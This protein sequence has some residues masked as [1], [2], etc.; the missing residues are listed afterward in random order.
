[1]TAIK[2]I[3]IGIGIGALTLSS[4]VY[5]NDQTLTAAT[6]MQMLGVSGPDAKSTT[7]RWNG[8]PTV[9]VDYVIDKAKVIGRGS[10]VWD[11][12]PSQH[13][14]AFTGERDKE[15]RLLVAVQQTPDGK[16]QST[17][18]T[19]VE[20]DALW[21]AVTAIGFANADKDPDKELVVIVQWGFNQFGSGG[22]YDYQVRIFKRPDPSKPNLTPLQA[23]SDHF[24]SQFDGYSDGGGRVRAKF[25]TIRSVQRELRRIGYK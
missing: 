11:E 13:V 4:A 16:L 21:S 18:V 17:I 20:S 12:P 14:D 7:A 9:F 6:A 2:C 25:K 15:L 8:Q 1:M 10:G 5:A 24:G 3:G 23:V 22:G 19:D